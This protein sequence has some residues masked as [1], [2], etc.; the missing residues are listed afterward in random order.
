MWV[1]SLDNC[2]QEFR[3]TPALELCKTDLDCMPVCVGKSQ[4]SDKHPRVLSRQ[5]EYPVVAALS[6]REITWY[7]A[8]EA[9]D[10]I[11]G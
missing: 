7:M 10:L 4:V 2:H 11:T 6:V 9:P 3:G 5:E 1:L 8:T